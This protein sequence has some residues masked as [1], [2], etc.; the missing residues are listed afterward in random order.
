MATLPSWPEALGAPLN[1]GYKHTVETAGSMAMTAGVSRTRR[2]IDE[3]VSEFSVSFVWTSEQLKQFRQFAR[4]EIDGTAGWFVMWLWSGGGM[5]SHTVRVA[6]LSK[7][8]K[9]MP[10]W[11]VSIT[12]ECPDRYRLPD[13]IGDSL[14]E[15]DIA[16][17]VAAGNVAEKSMCNVGAAH[18]CLGGWSVFDVVS[19]TNQALCNFGKAFN[20]WDDC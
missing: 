10:Y 19:E 18:D 20:D 8:Q 17:L 14:L 3:P 15:W 16:D 1:A 6:Q 11:Q 2:K 4:N 12:L 9:Q 5:E 7:Y 13:E